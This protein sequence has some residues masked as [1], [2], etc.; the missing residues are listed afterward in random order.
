MH[1]IGR[2][3]GLEGFGGEGGRGERGGGKREGEGVSE[4]REREKK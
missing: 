1:R 4:V 2:R 3:R